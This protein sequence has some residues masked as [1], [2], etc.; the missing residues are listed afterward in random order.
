MR[1]RVYFSCNWEKLNKMGIVIELHPR[2]KMHN[3]QVIAR[4]FL[5]GFTKALSKTP[6]NDVAHLLAMVIADITQSTMA[7]FHNH[8]CKK[9]GALAG[10]QIMEIIL[11]NLIAYS[12]HLHEQ[13][14]PDDSDS[15]H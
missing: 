1:K 7:D 3:Q 6:S 8:F 9:K 12:N 11:N 5:K 14:F 4:E 10:E 15:K 13:I 2:I